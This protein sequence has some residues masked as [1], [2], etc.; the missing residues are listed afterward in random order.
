MIPVVSPVCTSSAILFSK[1]LL[2]CAYISEELELLVSTSF[3]QRRHVERLMLSP[4]ASSVCQMLFIANY[5]VALLGPQPI[6]LFTSPW[7]VY[8]L[9]LK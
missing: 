7:L 9:L 2:P 8:M 4:D 5:V 1:Y 6:L 3:Q